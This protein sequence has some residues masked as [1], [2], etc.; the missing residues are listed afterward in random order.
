MMERI[1][2]LPEPLLPIKRTYNN[3][4]NYKYS[5]FNHT[6]QIGTFFF[7]M[8]GD[9]NEKRQHNELQRTADG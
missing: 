9:R 5:D 1:E 4:T 7:I 3:Y 6:K 2:V 8:V